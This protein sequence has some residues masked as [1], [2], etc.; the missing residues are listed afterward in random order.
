MHAIKKSLFKFLRHLYRNH[1]IF[2][3]LLILSLYGFFSS[4]ILSEFGIF[5]SIHNRNEI[6]KNVQS[7]KNN[8]NNFIKIKSKEVKYIENG[9]SYLLPLAFIK[10]FYFKIKKR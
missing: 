7:F 4:N 9:K 5:Q 8:L 3:L 10:Y 6:T 2:L 1:F